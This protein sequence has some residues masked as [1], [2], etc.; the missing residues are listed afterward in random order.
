[1][2]PFACLQA[3]TEV[4]ATKTER[5]ACPICMGPLS[6]TRGMSQCQRCQFVYCVGCEGGEWADASDSLAQRY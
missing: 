6:E 5:E 4:S 2:S 1:M 3:G